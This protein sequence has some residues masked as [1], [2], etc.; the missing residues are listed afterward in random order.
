MRGSFFPEGLTVEGEV[1]GAGDLV[2]AGVVLGPIQIEGTLVVEASGSVHGDVTARGVVL[3]GQLQGSAVAIETIRL[4]PGARM[5]GDAR[6]ERVTVVEG[7]LLR[8]RMTMTGGPNG[9]R[10]SAGNVAAQR[11]SSAGAIR[12]PG[13]AL[14]STAGALPAPSALPGAA[15]SPGVIAPTSSGGIRATTSTGAI[16]AA[17]A[18]RAPDAERSA[19]E[20]RSAPTLP[21]PSAAPPAGD[22]PLAPVAPGGLRVPTATGL[23]IEEREATGST[24]RPPPPV[25]PGVGRQRARRKDAGSGA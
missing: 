25:I 15:T 12:S 19:P 3:R 6:A 21:A 13:A 10:S 16:R 17:A 2:V 4:E 7:A 18:T 11:A 5:V 14:A 20:P 22:L 23:V 8:G 9:R 24:R 1:R